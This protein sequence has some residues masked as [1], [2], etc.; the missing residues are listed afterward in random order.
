VS[1]GPLSCSAIP[2]LNSHP[3]TINFRIISATNTRSPRPSSGSATTRLSPLSRNDQLHDHLR[4]RCTITETII[5]PVNVPFPR[6]SAG[7]LSSR[8]PPR[9][10]IR[11]QPRGRRR[12]RRGFRGSSARTSPASTL[13]FRANSLGTRDHGRVPVSMPNLALTTCPWRATCSGSSG[14]IHG[15]SSIEA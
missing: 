6:L 4:E 5:W 8:S 10:T 2:P 7:Q 14:A 9:P 12:A 1:S 11:G 15:D 13:G 3:K